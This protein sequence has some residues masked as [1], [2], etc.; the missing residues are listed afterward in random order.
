[1]MYS[2]EDARRRQSVDRSL[3]RRVGTYA[4][5]Y[6]TMLIGFITTIVLESALAL[7]PPF[8]FKAIVDDVLP[9]HDRVGLAWAAGG[10]VAAALA[11]AGLALVERYWSS[12]IG[13]GLIYD[14]RRAE[15]FDHVQRIPLSFFTRSQTGRPRQP[16]QQR[17]DR[18]PTCAHRH[19]GHGRLERHHP[20]GH[21]G[22]DDRPRVAADAG[23]RRA[24]AGV[25]PAGEAGRPSPR[26]RSPAT[27]CKLNAEMNAHHDRAL[28]RVGRA[29]GQAVRSHD[30]DRRVLDPGRRRVRDIGVRSAMLTR[31]F[32]SVMG[33]VGAVG[34]AAVYWLGGSRVI[35]GAITLGTLDRARRA[36][37]TDLRATHQRSRTPAST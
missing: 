24:A 34:T 15:L 12:R 8:I 19:A 27:A 7:A 14:L 29:A 32:M 3:V 36:R 2:D 11:A 26:R 25:H 30:R 9:G 37:R 33:L 4:R 28:R 6:R 21:P 10:I 31:T 13:E 16:P 23:R 35:D 20:G 18:R 22:G 17:R 1:M 5:P